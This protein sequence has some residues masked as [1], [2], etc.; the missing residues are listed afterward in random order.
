MNKLIIAALFA[1]TGCGEKT[2]HIQVAPVVK[3]PV[4]RELRPDYT[5]TDMTPGAVDAAVCLVYG[6]KL[7]GC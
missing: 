4:V 1:L 5:T 6:K 7:K 2:A 3:E